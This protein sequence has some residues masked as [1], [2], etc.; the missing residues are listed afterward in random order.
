MEIHLE[1]MRRTSG[2]QFIYFILLFEVGTIT[3]HETNFLWHLGDGSSLS[4]SKPELIHMGR[5]NWNLPRIRELKSNKKDNEKEG[6]DNQEQ[7]SLNFMW[8]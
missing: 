5:E 4:L 7:A 6:S 1:G 2:G 3:V 8:G